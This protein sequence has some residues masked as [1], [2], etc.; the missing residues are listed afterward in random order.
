[1]P[2]DWR[3]KA[4]I[5]GECNGCLLC[6]TACDDGGFQAITGIKGEVVTIDGE[7]CDGCGLCM[8]ICPLESIAMVP[9]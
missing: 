4:S 3:V 2:L 8:M 5:N 7:L 9:R 1:M 6:I